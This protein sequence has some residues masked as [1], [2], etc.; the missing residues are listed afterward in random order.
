MC[1]IIC[2]GS[3][4]QLDQI[5]AFAFKHKQPI[6]AASALLYGMGHRGYHKNYVRDTQNPQSTPN[7]PLKFKNATNWDRLKT[8]FFFENNSLAWSQIV[9]GGAGAAAFSVA[10]LSMLAATAFF[11]TVN[12]TSE[13]A[14]KWYLNR[15]LKQK[16]NITLQADPKKIW[17]E[18]LPQLIPNIQQKNYAI[19]NGKREIGRVIEL[20][21]KTNN[22]NKHTKTLLV[23][24]GSI[25]TFLRVWPKLIIAVKRRLN[26]MKNPPTVNIA[27][28]RQ[29]HELKNTSRHI[30]KH[31]N[32]NTK[33][34]SFSI[35]GNSAGAASTVRQSQVFDEMG[36]IPEN[37][38]MNS[39]VIDGIPMPASLRW[40]LKPAE[41]TFF[42]LG[43]AQLFRV[44][45]HSWHWSI[46]ESTKMS[47]NNQDKTTIVTHKDDWFTRGRFLSHTERLH[48]I[49][50]NTTIIEQNTKSKSPHNY[51]LDDYERLN[52][53]AKVFLPE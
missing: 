10:P 38:L 25:G 51:F 43:L 18:N 36:I 16:S 29:G 24:H 39:P 31:F 35:L 27:F 9:L 23:N 32:E 8:A 17:S 42:N 45:H 2:L 26:E 40:F 49:F 50:P 34:H 20:K 12:S 3:M 7:T 41:R 33:N 1:V 14:R 5:K 53:A 15:N 4:S 46:D 13:S 19:C 44:S 47:K 48:N 28:V 21:S 30:I 22:K 6:A 37:I 11:Y 52:E